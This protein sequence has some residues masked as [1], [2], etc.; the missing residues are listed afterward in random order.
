MDFCYWCFFF[1]SPWPLR[2]I[3]WSHQLFCFVSHLF[4]QYLGSGIFPRVWD[5]TADGS[6][7]S[8][9]L[10][11]PQWGFVWPLVE[12]MTIA[13]VLIKDFP[14][15]R[16]LSH[17]K[18]F[19]IMLLTRVSDSFFLRGFSILSP[20]TTPP[21]F[22]VNKDSFFGNESCAISSHRKKTP[23]PVVGEKIMLWSHCC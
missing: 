9:V 18:I 7:I 14:Y 4:I 12:K 22:E 15:Y 11:L 23:L 5:N 21:F 1:L 19:K 16:N 17:L 3:M 2:L 6:A 20:S 8:T 13:M 10:I